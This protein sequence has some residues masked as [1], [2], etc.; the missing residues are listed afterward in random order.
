MITSFTS[1]VFA[2][3]PHSTRAASHLWR[4]TASIDASRFTSI[5]WSKAKTMAIT[6][7]I[8]VS[9]LIASTASAN[10]GHQP[11]I[12]VAASVAA[13]SESIARRFLAKTGIQV[14]RSAGASGN[15][16]HQIRRGAP[17]ELFISADSSYVQSIVDSGLNDGPG[18]TYAIGQLALLVTKR[19]GL[20]L[21]TTQIPASERE[22]EIRRLL[23]DPRIERI[24]IA[25]PQHAPYGRAARE[26]LQF[27]GLWEALKV[28][29]VFGE[30]VAQSARFASTDSVQATLL[31]LGI[32]M[33]SPLANE[34]HWTVPTT[35]HQ[36]LHQQMILIKGASDEAKRLF[37]FMRDAD[38]RD[39]LSEFGFLVPASP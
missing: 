1:N 21:P 11:I 15:L 30:S 12:A 39:V 10:Q 29:T 2:L 33:H 32:I 36:P 26:S 34:P 8:A 14:R 6:A 17:F 4:M 35:W 31:P 16:A 20:V 19:S 28:K 7:A 37:A 24:T 22:N 18:V 25:N 9:M 27:L 3:A 5:A 38:T 23:R 13:A